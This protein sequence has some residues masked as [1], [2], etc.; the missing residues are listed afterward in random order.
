M[1]NRILATILTLS[2]G[3]EIESPYGANALERAMQIR[4]IALIV[5]AVVIVVALIYWF[6]KKK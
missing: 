4:S 5:G 6:T 2:A 1:L 3:G